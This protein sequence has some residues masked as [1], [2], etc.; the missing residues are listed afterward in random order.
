VPVLP[1]TIRHSN[2]LE[3]GIGTRGVT[4]LPWPMI[5][6][7]EASLTYRAPDTG[8]ELREEG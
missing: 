5:F 4:L 3:A 2:A 8:A 6:R 1:R 7:P